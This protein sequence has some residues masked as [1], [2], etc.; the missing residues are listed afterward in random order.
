[1]GDDSRKD[2]ELWAEERHQG[3]LGQR[4]RVT[5]TLF[6]GRSEFQQV[7]VVETAGHGRMLFIDGLAMVSERDEFVYHEMMAHVPLFVHPDPRRVLVIGGGD[8]GTLREALRHRS[9]EHV[10]MVEIDPLV[11]ES[12]KEHIPQTACAMDDPRAEVTIGDGVAFA[13]ETD[14]K[15]DVVLVDSTDPI[16]PATPLFGEKFY[17]DVNRILR[18]DGI[19]ISQ[20]ESPWYEPTWQ[21][22]IVSI[23]VGTFARV[24]VYN[25][26]N[27]TY[28]GG[29]WSFS[30]ASKSDRCP[31]ASLDDDRVA[32]ADIECRYYRPDV[33]RAAFA[34]P[35]FQRAALEKTVS[36]FGGS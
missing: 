34:L 11:V 30:Y 25:Y 18:E 6:S 32:R 33:H 1:M 14:E 22:K 27:L 35:E 13:A 36:V 28:P 15:F 16:G 8:G 31:I 17:T 20:A 3:Y 26:S 2:L 23:L 24:H 12:C 9:V 29:L 7:D 19:V 5:R 21:R 10:R 4:F